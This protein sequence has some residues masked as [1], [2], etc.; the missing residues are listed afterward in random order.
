MQTTDI[1]IPVAGSELGATCWT[2]PNPQGV[3][4]VHPATAVTQGFYT[5]FATYLAS[6]GLHVITYDYRGTGRSR[7]TSL[8]GLKV[9]M[10]DWIDA[11]VPAATAW[12]A[13]RFPGLPLL[14]VGHSIGGHALA[15]SPSSARLRAAILVA[16]HAGATRT[17]RGWA[18]RQRVRFVLGV[19]SPLLCRLL[20]Y[21]PGSRLGLGEDL[22]SGVMLQWAGWCGRPNY[23]FDDQAM[24]AARRMA[25]NR[26]PLQVLS[27][28]DDPWANPVAVE[29]L[30]SR[31][32]NAR[33]E[34]RHIAPRAAGL[35][36]IGH[37]G[38][39]RRRSAALWP[40]AADWLLAHCA[41]QK[42]AQHA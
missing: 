6:R 39:F 2:V 5:A 36:A 40:E 26:L 41:A 9:T 15:L 23:F 27:F 21:M 34:R 10:A 37:M 1:T 3:V 30:V 28:E 11:D 19:L 17:V 42:E 35:P 13:Q 16:S 14:A 25:A 12:A 24:D 29:M 22:P 33:L 7:P 18:E 8:R 20:G 31:L 4:I 32:V 38:W